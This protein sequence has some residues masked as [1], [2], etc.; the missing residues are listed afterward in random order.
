MEQVIED[1]NDEQIELPENALL[2]SFDE[3]YIDNYL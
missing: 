2:L 3:G 1:W